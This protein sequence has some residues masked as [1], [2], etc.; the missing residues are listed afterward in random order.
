MLFF[1][2]LFSHS[3]AQM[4]CTQRQTNLTIGHVNAK[5]CFLTQ[6]DFSSTSTAQCLFKPKHSCLTLRGFSFSCIHQT[7]NLKTEAVLKLQCDS[8]C[9]AQT[10]QTAFS[11]FKIKMSYFILI[12]KS[13][14]N[15]RLYY[16]DKTQSF[17][18]KPFCTAVFQKSETSKVDLL[19]YVRT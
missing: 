1:I 7:I 11:V 4:G 16:P 12:Y 17:K 9:G 6:I 13:T 18:L 3:A 5:F 15:I 10:F 2:G 19:V 8:I 14:K